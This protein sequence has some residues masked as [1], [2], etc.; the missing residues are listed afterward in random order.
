MYQSG[1]KSGQLPLN[2][3]YNKTTHPYNSPHLT[4]P[5]HHTTSSPQDN[6]PIYNS[7]RS[8]PSPQRLPLA[9][10]GEKSYAIAMM[11]PAFCRSAV[12]HAMPER[13][14]GKPKETL[15]S[16]SRGRVHFISTAELAPA[17]A[18]L[19]LASKWSNYQENTFLNGSFFIVWL[20]VSAHVWERGCYKR[21]NSKTEYF[22][23]AQNQ[24]V[25]FT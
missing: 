9:A 23:L 14:V 18:A 6:S 25:P 7:P 20:N 2:D 8:H 13:S 3:R 22:G 12:I 21:G 15:Y 5:T 24:L 11:V 4:P 16:T 17:F 10:S 19:P 1:P